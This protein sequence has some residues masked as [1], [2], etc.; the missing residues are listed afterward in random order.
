MAN[1][2]ILA[3]ELDVAGSASSLTY[4]ESGPGPIA[5]SS[6]EL[7]V[8]GAYERAGPDLAITGPGGET[9]LI[10]GYFDQPVA[11]ALEA[12]GGVHM[13]ADLVAKLAGPLAPAQYAQTDSA[14]GQPIGEIVTL[15]GA[16]QVTRASGEVVS[17]ALGGAVF[18]N[19][20]IETGDSG[21][22]GISLVDETVLTINSSSRMV[23]DELV[24]DPASGS[25][26]ML[27]SLVSGSFGFL[28]GE[29]APSGNM[30]LRTPVTTLGIRGTAGAITHLLL[31]SQVFNFLDFRIDAY[32]VIELAN[33]V[34]ELLG[35]L[36]AA[37]TYGVYNGE[38]GVYIQTF[39]P[40]E[41]EF[42]RDTIY[43]LLRDAAEASGIDVTQ[44]IDQGNRHPATFGDDPTGDGGAPDDD[45]P[46]DLEP[47]GVV[48]QVRVTTPVENEDSSTDPRNAAA[49]LAVV[50]PP[51]A[52]E[53]NTANPVV[54]TIADQVVISD[55]GGGPPVAFEPGSLVFV[56]AI[57]PS[58]TG[59]PTSR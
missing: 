44:I 14:A 1:R 42:L 55:P 20:V 59:G 2:R 33:E 56:S 31:I 45:Q 46:G 21:T 22:I 38:T 43:R 51:A 58:P 32:G 48:Q 8:Y 19:D 18:A 29:I 3:E 28:S 6:A 13:G 40:P 24:Y 41:L 47:D 27:L 5:V 35:R 10:L 23:L 25:G 34:G 50:D 30:V 49:T 52:V 4:I 37:D 39:V 16:V 36:T 12:P 15:D 7:L 57:G 9:V 11:P 26:S 53:S 17:A 54:V